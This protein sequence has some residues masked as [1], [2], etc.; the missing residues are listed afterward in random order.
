METILAAYRDLFHREDIHQAGLIGRSQ[1]NRALM[2]VGVKWD[3][4]DLDELITIYGKTAPEKL[5]VSEYLLALRHDKLEPAINVDLLRSKKISLLDR[6]PSQASGSV[7]TRGKG[8]ENS[9]L[10][11]GQR[12]RRG[13][14]VKSMVKRTTSN[15]GSHV[16]PSTGKIVQPVSNVQRS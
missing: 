10:G 11:K 15:S 12:L 13:D 5:T 2:S 14:S 3:Q 6:A 8:Q 4:E 1:L 9:R 7:D 16:G